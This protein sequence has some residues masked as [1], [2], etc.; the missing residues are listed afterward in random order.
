MISRCDEDGWTIQ[1]NDEEEYSYVL[2]QI[3]P[4]VQGLLL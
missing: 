1:F 4:Q 3:L 2:H